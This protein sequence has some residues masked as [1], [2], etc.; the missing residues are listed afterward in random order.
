LRDEE[1]ASQV[2]ADNPP[3]LI[4]FDVQKAG[5]VCDPCIVDEHIYGGRGLGSLYSCDNVC[6]FGDVHGHRSGFG[7][8]STQC[9]NGMCKV[10]LAAVEQAHIC[11]FA[12]NWRA[13]S[14]PMPRAAPVMMMCLFENFAMQFPI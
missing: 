12:C 2:H 4:F 7:A 14:S 1:G 13:I 10:I 11:S 6:P 3:P 9:G 8:C 5:F